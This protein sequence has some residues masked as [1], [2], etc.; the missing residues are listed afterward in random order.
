MIL[1]EPNALKVASSVLRGKG[2]SDVPTLP[3]WN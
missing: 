3:D 1:L 2:D